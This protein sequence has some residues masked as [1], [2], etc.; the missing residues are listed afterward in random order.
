MLIG[1][2]LEVL[3]ISYTKHMVAMDVGKLAPKKYIK[4]MTLYINRPLQSPG[5]S[6]NPLAYDN[7]YNLIL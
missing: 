1:G 6:I 7:I 2:E 3:N 4:L 5:K